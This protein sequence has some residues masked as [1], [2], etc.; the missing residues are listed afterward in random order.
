MIQKTSHSVL[1]VS[2]GEKGIDA[3]T[4]LLR[5]NEFSAVTTVKSSGEARRLLSVQNFDIIIINTPLSDE[6]GTELALQLAENTCSG[7]ML[8]TKADISEVVALKTEDLGVITIA[9]PID[10]TLFHHTLKLLSAV[11]DKYAVLENENKKLKQKL[12]E[13]R[14]VQRAKRMLME[15]LHMSESQAHHYI[16]RQAMDMRITKYEVANSII[17]TYTDS[18]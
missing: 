16:E 17:R 12:D 18:Y 4:G 9:K 15:C 5:N 8:I 6:F 11:R 2:S 10:R 7:I 3:I 13:V 14:L 1:L